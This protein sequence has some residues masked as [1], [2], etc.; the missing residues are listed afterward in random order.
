MK[1]V[2]PEGRTIVAL[3]GGADSVALLR[4]LLE[5]A[6]DVVA[7]HC[8][9][10]LRAEESDRDERFVRDLC[11][12]LGVELHVRHFDT[13]G[14]ARA[15]G[16]SVEMA[17]RELRYEWFEAMRAELGCDSIAVAH[18]QDDQAETV[19][20][21]LLRG[22]GLR[23]L[24]GMRRRNG[25]IVRPLLH[26]AKQ[27]LLAYLQSIGQDYVEDSTNLQR[28]A[29]RNRLRL[30]VMPLLRNIN[31]RVVEHICRTAELV[32]SCLGTHEEGGYTLHSLDEWLRPHGFNSAQIRAKNKDQA[33]S[34]GAVYE[35]P[36]HRLLRNRGRLVLE[37]RGATAR[38][39]LQYSIV[40]T[41]APLDF[42]K[43]QP[44][45]PDH[46][47]LDAD[48]LTMPLTQR[49]WE[50]G[51]RFHPFGMRGSR[52]VSDF[53][54]DIKLSRF[55]KERQC[56]LLSGKDIVWV[57]GRRP[58]NRYRVTPATRR[59]CHIVARQV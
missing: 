33:G 1:L 3:S 31:P 26:L 15:K 50:R 23:G 4:L 16:V 43:S 49:L 35:S 37:E 6:A 40:E 24:V 39:K 41:D 28:G 14:Y 42:V 8:N 32:E 18:H 17:A 12:R 29:L 47:Y 44:L 10:H 58:D 20:L 52:L 5:A 9:F 51:D 13:L 59:V 34:S 22:T 21:N 30:D 19:L 2:A 27:E 45:T 56:I 53:L 55:D 57:V 48:K 54:T 25:H 38:C 7:L 46:A 11:A 36:T